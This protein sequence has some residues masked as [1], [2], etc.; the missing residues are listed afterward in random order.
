MSDP[1]TGRS[2]A[3]GA[4]RMPEVAEEMRRRQGPQPEHGQL[5]WRPRARG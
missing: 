4:S 3:R 1:N 5:V 2:A